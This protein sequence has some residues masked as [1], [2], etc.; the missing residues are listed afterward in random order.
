MNYQEISK[1]RDR[2]GA[3]R[4]GLD[5]QKINP[6]SPP[7]KLTDCGIFDNWNTHGRRK[8]YLATNDGLIGSYIKNE[9]KKKSEKEGKRKRKKAMRLIRESCTRRPLSQ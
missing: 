9:K 3:R 7:M 6:D 2:C 5:A 4:R 8:D 1:L